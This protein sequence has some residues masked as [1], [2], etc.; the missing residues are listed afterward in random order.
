MDD[1]LEPIAADLDPASPE[2]LAAQQE[3]WRHT[4]SRD[5]QQA[6]ALAISLR[7]QGYTVAE[8]CERIGRTEHTL[9]WWKGKYPLWAK[10]WKAARPGATK[11]QTCDLDFPTF[12]AKVLGRPLPK[13]AFPWVDAMTDPSIETLLVLCPPFFAKSTILSV[14]WAAWRLACNRTYRLARISQS[15]KYAAKLVRTIT[16]ILLDDTAFPK[17]DAYRPFRLDA[18]QTKVADTWQQHMFYVEGAGTEFHSP[19]VEAKG[20]GSQIYGDRF[21]EIGLDDIADVKKNSP[22]MRAKHKD[23]IVQDCLSRLPH[24]EGKLYCVATRVGQPDMYSEL[25]DEGF[26]DH[27]IEQKALD[28]ETGKSLWPS[29]WPVEK[30]VKQRRRVGESRWAL[31]YQQDPMEDADAPFP[32][33]LVYDALDDSYSVEKHRDFAA[34]N[35]LITVMGFDPA[36]AGWCVATLY[37]IRPSAPHHRFVLDMWRERDLSSDIEPFFV[38]AA[39]TWRPKRVVIEDNNFQRFFR[40]Q[41][42][43]IGVVRSLQITVQ[44]H[45]TGT[46][47][48]D[49]DLGVSSLPNLFYDSLVHIPWGSSESRKRMQPFLDEL[50]YWRP[51]DRDL[52][53]DTVMAFWFAE[54]GARRALPELHPRQVHRTRGLGA[55]PLRLVRQVYDIT[56]E[57]YV[58]T[59]RAVR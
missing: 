31:V 40:L 29:A 50:C 14:Q 26:F 15:E 19:S 47:K 42:D 11:W 5:R 9:S 13:H 24:T 30:L 34:K 51:Y 46:N 48:Y 39:R 45:Q 17:M 16:H 27:V 35:G 8:I 7:Q 52:T 37:G 55:M 56:E 33:T 25:R 10:Q 53:Q 23:V 54:L 57:P 32:K 6:Q 12:C 1:D 43:I 58:S 21:H 3:R 4:S 49:P 59:Q 44:P 28:P 22:D 41:E 2:R 18:A 38:E 20:I 36:V